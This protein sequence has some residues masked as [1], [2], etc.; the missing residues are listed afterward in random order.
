MICLL[1]VL[2]ACRC[3]KRNK[4]AE[5]HISSHDRRSLGG[6]QMHKDG[7]VYDSKVQRQMTEPTEHSGW[8][9]NNAYSSHQRDDVRDYL[10]KK[11]GV[12]PSIFSARATKTSNSFE[13]REVGYENTDSPISG[14]RST[15]HG[16]AVDP[17]TGRIYEYN[18]LNGE[19]RWLG[20]A[21]ETADMKNNSRPSTA[22]SE[23]PANV[24]S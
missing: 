1:I 7:F 20:S 8:G 9:S 3:W 16:K 15:Y 4:T 11:E 13:M 19:R 14:K 17:E 18:T 12:H 6:R 2:L 21:T 22:S 24:S 23:V 10:S 5:E